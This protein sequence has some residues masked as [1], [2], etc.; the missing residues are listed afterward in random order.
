MF[1]TQPNAGDTVT[2]GEDTYTF[3]NSITPSTPGYTVL[4]GASPNA[5]ATNLLDAITFD[6]GA[7]TNEG[8]TYG[9]NTVANGQIA[10]PA[11][12]GGNS[13]NVV[14]TATIGGT[15]YVYLQVFTLTTGLPT[16]LPLLLNPPE[17]PDL[18]GLR[19]LYLSDLTS[20]LSWVEQTLA[21]IQQ[22]LETP[23]GS[24]SWTPT[25]TS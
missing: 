21:S 24:N 4:I 11:N 6:N 7:G 1:L 14:G 23:H 10:T 20:L 17:P 15:P 16:M 22:S 3:T 9:N 25:P 18:T 2:V 12:N 13:T 19:V 8:I 5:T